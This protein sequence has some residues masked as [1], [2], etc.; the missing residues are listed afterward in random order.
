MLLP[1]HD[2]PAQRL[3]GPHAADGAAHHLAELGVAQLAEAGLDRRQL[4]RRLLPEPRQRLAQVGVEA[5][6]HG[7]R[8]AELA[9]GGGEAGDAAGL[10]GDGT[11]AAE[12]RPVR[13]LRPL[14]GQILDHPVHVPIEAVLGVAEAALGLV[15]GAAERQAELGEEALDL[16][17]SGSRACDPGAGADADLAEA[18]EAGFRLR[19]WAAG[20]DPRTL[21]LMGGL[22]R[23]PE[24]AATD[25]VGHR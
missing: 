19:A 24:A 12:Q 5:C 14:V 13:Q 23:D 17:A 8:V 15:G 9:F 20:L 16:D 10:A 4:V 6:A 25:A 11:E 3:G 21:G 1:A 7:G 2:P 18:V 22:P